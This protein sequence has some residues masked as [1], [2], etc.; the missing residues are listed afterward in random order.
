MV[1]RTTT[2]TTHYDV[3]QRRRAEFIEEW[4]QYQRCVVKAEDVKMVESPKRGMKSGVFMGVDG[5]RPSRLLDAIMHEIDPGKVSSVHRHS[6][7]AMMLVLEGS[8]WTEVNGVRYEWRP[9]DSVY[10]PAWAWHRQ[11]NNSDKPARYITFSSEPLIETLNL[12]ILEDAGDTETSE[13]PGIPQYTPGPDGDDPY[14]RRLRRLSRI[15][16]NYRKARVLTNYDDLTMLVNKKGS[17]STFL[18]DRAIDNLTTGLTMVMLQLAP[19]RWQKKH[20][21]GGEAWL[22]V[23]EGRGHSEID[24]QSHE[25]K[26][27]DLI[28][29]DHWA[30]HQHFNDDPNE[31][32]RLVRVHNFD[33][34]YETMRAILDPLALHE[35][36]QGSEPDVAD[37]DWP[38]DKRPS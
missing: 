26:A 2:G 9:W 14:A 28:V 20:R 33:S 21:H 3:Q 32:A 7:D 12:A 16:D 25:W 5:D 13:L 15:Q 19:G 1:S 38:E 11:G 4:R 24:G 6:W 31:P 27:G 30:W 10:L 17:R 29:V 36:E 8:G 22:Y 23:L 34:V 35:E 37:V 18:V